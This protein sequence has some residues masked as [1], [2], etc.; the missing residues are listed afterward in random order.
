MNL[1]IFIVLLV[2]VFVLFMAAEYLDVVLH[3]GAFAILFIL[4]VTILTNNLQYKTGESL[5][6]NFTY[7]ASPFNESINQ[8]SAVRQDVYAT[9]SDTYSRTV[10]ILLAALSVFGFILVYVHYGKKRGS[11]D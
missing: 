9:Y 6:T 7:A 5:T 3:V 4:G 1:T 2:L 11:D 8:T 10:G